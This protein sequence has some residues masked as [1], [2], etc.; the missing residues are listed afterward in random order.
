[1]NVP[2]AAVV[3]TT[4][5]TLKKLLMGVHGCVLLC[6]WYICF[7]V[8]IRMFSIVDI[9]VILCMC[10]GAGD[11]ASLCVHMFVQARA[12][13]HVCTFRVYF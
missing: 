2:Y 13:V 9:L 12:Q 3:V 7:G 6:T 11:P 8:S 4:N 1:M 10:V 5:E